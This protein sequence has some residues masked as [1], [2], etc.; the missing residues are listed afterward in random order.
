MFALTTAVLGFTPGAPLSMAPARAVAAT[1]IRMNAGGG[2]ETLDFTGGSLRSQ[3]E[4][5]DEDLT[6]M[7][8]RARPSIDWSN[9]RARLEVEFGFKEEELTKYDSVSKEDLLKVLLRR[10]GRSMPCAS[11]SRPCVQSIAL[12]PTLTLT[13]GPRP[14][15][16]RGAVC[17]RAQPV[18][19]DPCA[20]PVRQAYEMMQLC[21]QFENACNQAY[22]QGNIRGFM[23]LD[24]GQEAI[25]A[26][27]ADTIKK[28]DKKLSYYRV[29]HRS[30]LTLTGRSCPA[31][32]LRL[33]SRYTS[34]SPFCRSTRT[35]SRRACLRLLGSAERHCLSAHR[36]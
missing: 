17:S 9:L 5:T 23:H 16:A 26:L 21:R 20:A 22:M 2:T 12:T 29:S 18:C 32:R 27:I 31:R 28:G 3:K 14:V 10:A 7:G 36:V 33:G 4:L 11:L 1:Q 35:R 13:V 30:C 8:R 24:N 6:S 19:V 25:P 34:S 15:A